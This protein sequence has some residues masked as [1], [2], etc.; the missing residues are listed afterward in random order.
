VSNTYL[1][2]DLG[3]QS[4]RAILGHVR[5]GL[6]EL[7]E[8]RRF[9]ND[10]LL[11]GGSMRWNV[12]ALW[13]EM[14]HAL[15]SAARNARL[16]SVGVDSWGVDYALLGPRGELVE[17]PY[18]YRDARTDGV[19]ETVFELVSPDDI[20][21]VTGI[22]FLRINTLFQLSA[23]RLLT[24]RVLDTA[25]GLVMIPDLMNYWLTGRQCSE[26]TVATTTQ[27]VDARTCTWAAGLMEQAGLPP[28]I[29][30]E[31]VPPGTVLGT[32]SAEISRDA[33][34]TPVVAPGCHDTASA[35]ASVDS[36]SIALIS[37]GTWSLL[38]TETEVPVITRTARDLDFTNEGGVCGTIR[39]LKNIA[40]LWLL[41]ECRRVWASEGRP[42]DHEDL[43]A[44]AADVRPFASLIDPD[45]RAFLNPRDMPAEIARFCER[46]GQPVPATRAAYARAI[47]E[48]LAFK[49]RVALEALEAVTGR[50]FEQIRIVGGGSRNR[51]LNQFTADATGRPVLAGP[52]EATALGNIAMQMVATGAAASLADARTLIRRSFPVER[53][54][55]SNTRLWDEHYQRFFDCVDD[56]GA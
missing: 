37:S 9:P 21:G 6:L 15:A 3:A 16:S 35:F 20:Y 12:V 28:R 54:E 27:L 38:G 17:N 23:A 14:R 31:I 50:R 25:R 18:H 56:R 26:Y 46:T 2:F 13:E 45:D 10:P 52:S 44:S 53:L 4:G 40:G 39:L 41:E 49:Y 19:M 30:P 48:S 43:I 8:I 29:L 5:A 1:A 36:G 22:Q 11:Q 32:I 51:L 42:V 7:R 34:G 47:L 33:A 55:P 24:P